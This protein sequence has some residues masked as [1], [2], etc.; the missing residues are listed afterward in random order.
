[1]RVRFNA[2]VAS[3]NSAATFPSPRIRNRRIPRCTFKIPMTGPLAFPFFQLSTLNPI[4]TSL[5]P[6]FQH[7]FLQRSSAP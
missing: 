2:V 6:C 4:Q 7:R 5:L 3:A 1:M